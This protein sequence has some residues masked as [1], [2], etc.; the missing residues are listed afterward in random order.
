MIHEGSTT[1]LSLI[2]REY[3]PSGVEAVLALATSGLRYSLLCTV[4]CSWI[5][6]PG[7]CS[8]VQSRTKRNHQNLPSGEHGLREKYIPEKG[9]CFLFID[10]A[11]EELCAIA[12]HCKLFFGHSLMYDL[13]NHGLDLHGT[14]A[15]YRDGELTDYDIRNLSDSDIAAIR[16]LNDLYK[17]DDDL[18]KSRKLAKT[19]NFSLGGKMGVKGFYLALR[20]GGFKL[21][22]EEAQKLYNDWFSFYT[23]VSEMHKL[24]TDGEVCAAVFDKTNK[25]QEEEDSDSTETET[26]EVRSFLTDANG[27][28]IEDPER[29]VQLYRV[30]NAL[31]MVKARGTACAVANFIF[32]SYAAAANKI[33]LW[34]VF[35]SE[36]KRSK[37][38]GVPPRFKMVVFIHDEIGAE[39][40]IDAV[41]EVA[42]TNS[43]LMVGGVK[44][45]MPGVFIKTEATAMDRWSKAAK[46]RYDDQGHIVINHIEI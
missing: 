7:T 34:W 28:P 4:M 26:E 43:E 33:A 24:Q 1:I 30:T 29:M 11:Q 23:E 5:K 31:G 27:Q 6:Y 17:E 13:I 40:D 18:A 41:D 20:N 12:Q 8:R 32:Q 25:Q 36:W 38:L 2:P 9:R 22:M 44:S 35:Y 14:F 42:K 39:V 10:F 16:K 45:V 3:T 21:T 46:S 19:T 37:T 15:A